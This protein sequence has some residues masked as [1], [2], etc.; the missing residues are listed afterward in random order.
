[1]FDV[2]PTMPSSFRVGPESHGYVYELVRD[3]FY[4]C[5]RGSDRCRDGEVL[6]L[7]REG[8]RIFMSNE[9][10]REEGQHLWWWNR[11]ESAAEPDWAEET[12]QFETLILT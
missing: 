2:F 11:N 8:A 7:V 1:M 12:M 10:I 9:E 3:R 6:F 4:Q 5:V